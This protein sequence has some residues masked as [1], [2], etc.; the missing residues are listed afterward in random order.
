MKST[1][2]VIFAIVA[3][4]VTITGCSSP[5]KR[6]EIGVTVGFNPQLQSRLLKEQNVI[7]AV[8]EAD[9]GGQ[10]RLVEMASIQPPHAPGREV[11]AYFHDLSFVMPAFASNTAW[12][13]ATGTFQCHM[14]DKTKD[15]EYHPCGTGSRLV[16]T[17]AATTAA[18]SGIAVLLTGGLAAGVDRGLNLPLI[19]TMVADP[20]FKPTADRFAR[21]KRDYVEA[22]RRA[23]KARL[24]T[25]FEVRNNSELEIPTLSRDTVQVRTERRHQAARLSSSVSFTDS[26]RS[27][28]A[29]AQ[30]VA[31]NVEQFAE[32]GT[33][34]VICYL[35]SK[36]PSLDM[37]FTCSP[38]PVRAADGVARVQVVV[39]VESMSFGTRMPATRFSDK[40]LLVESD[41]VRLLVTN[42]SDRFVS[43][44]ALT[45]YG[46]KQSWTL[47][48]ATPALIPPKASHAVN[49]N[50][51]NLG[52]VFN[53]NRV[54][55]SDLK[56]GKV[57]FGVA[58]KY[59][60]GGPNP[61]TLN[62]VREFDR[63]DFLPKGVRVAR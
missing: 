13:G 54:R 27:V 32:R 58:V 26:A 15:T 49:M 29:L 19:A 63:A 17:N 25:A 38:D 47:P 28:D 9:A 20:L 35:T 59:D 18:R 57:R 56:M 61:E 21:L 3:L 52:G 10:L 55:G 24:E 31:Q 30:E 43:I 45:V 12:N 41:G 48:Y 50:D 14:L 2:A 1:F 34:N 37:R 4:V 16:A 40:N 23:P 22:V 51:L 46:E 42:A 39:T 44:R 11:L 5:A 36:I 53:M 7:F 60:A 62:D 6:T 8:Y 33:Y